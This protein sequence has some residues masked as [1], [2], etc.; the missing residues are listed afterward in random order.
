M[1]RFQ[2]Y[3]AGILIGYSDLESG[4]APMGVA[5]GKF[6]PMPAYEAVRSSTTVSWTQKELASQ[7]HLLLVVRDTE[8]R[9]I[10]SSGG[11][12]ILDYS[13]ELG[14]EGLTVDILGVGYPLYEEIF[15]QHVAAYKNV[16]KEKA[17]KGNP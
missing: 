10:P 9:D 8:G 14:P 17:K 1:P 5:S 12:Q 15:P 7:S 6:L 3:S 4:D 16:W 2:V 11:V 13:E